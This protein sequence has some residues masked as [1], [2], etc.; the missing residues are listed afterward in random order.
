MIKELNTLEGLGDRVP[1]TPKKEDKDLKLKERKSRI[2]N[3]KEQIA[4]RLISI[5]QRI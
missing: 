4:D 3:L 1:K 5:K 2:E